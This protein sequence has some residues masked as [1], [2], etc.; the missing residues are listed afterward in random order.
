MDNIIFGKWRDLNSQLLL[1]R[2]FLELSVKPF[3][4]TPIAAEK[5]YIVGYHVAQKADEGITHNPSLKHS[6][7]KIFDATKHTEIP[8]IIIR[9]HVIKGKN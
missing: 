7:N 3:D 5:D 8:E 2:Q 9:I 4:N 1:E 6:S